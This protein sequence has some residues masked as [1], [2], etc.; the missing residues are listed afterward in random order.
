MDKLKSIV[1]DLENLPGQVK[2]KIF[3]IINADT[4]TYVIEEGSLVVQHIYRC[5]IKNIN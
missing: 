5:K 1:E 4:E 3:D 2:R